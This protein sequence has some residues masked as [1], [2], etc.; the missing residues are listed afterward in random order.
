MHPHQRHLQT[1]SR[2]HLLQDSVMG[3][4]SIALDR[5]SA[6]TCLPL[7]NQRQR[8]RSHQFNLFRSTREECHL[9]A[10]GRCAVA[11]GFV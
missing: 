10:H 5:C 2:R 6:T 3:L 4:G 8:C 7:R 9:P 1:L 11:S